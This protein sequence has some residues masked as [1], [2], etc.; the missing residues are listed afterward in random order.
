MGQNKEHAA[1]IILVDENDNPVGFETK[2]KAHED[3]GKL[4]R[5]FSIFIFD[6]IGR[7][8]LQRRAK[9]KYHFG[10][11]WTNACCGHPKRG[12]TLQDAARV[13]LRQ[14]FG[15]EAELNGIFSFVYRASDAESGLSEYEFDH[16]F[17]G[18]F[19]GEPHPNPDEIDDWKWVDLAK[20]RADLEGNQHDYT[21]WFRI[22]VPQVIQNLPDTDRWCL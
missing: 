19:N 6:A 21:P 15:F 10:G 8:L 18:E 9:G 17:H 22:A 5:A 2:L 7:M 16:V 4:H 20:L 14:E 13:R 1:E 11:L 12:E 3:G